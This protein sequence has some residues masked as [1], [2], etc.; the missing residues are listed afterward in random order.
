MTWSLSTVKFTLQI[1]C[2]R[3]IQVF[4]IMN[5]SQNDNDKSEWWL[6]PT[7]G[8]TLSQING[9]T[10]NRTNG[11]WVGLEQ[12]YSTVQLLKFNK[13]FHNI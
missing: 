4:K 7:S 5:Y 8:Q 6:R 2:Y 13:Y 11:L 10:F 3:L 1:S 12:L 9:V